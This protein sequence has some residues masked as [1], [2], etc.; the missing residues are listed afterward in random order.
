MTP[1]L[2]LI[3]L[4]DTKIKKKKTTKIKIQHFYIPLKIIMTFSFLM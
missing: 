3:K 4:N 2:I 1:T